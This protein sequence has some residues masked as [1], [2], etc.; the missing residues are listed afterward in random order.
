MTGYGGAQGWIVFFPGM[1]DH[2]FKWNSTIVS[3]GG[4]GNAEEVVNII[5]SFMDYFVAVFPV[6]TGVIIH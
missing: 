3:R 6:M 1:E 2:I 4:A 5:I